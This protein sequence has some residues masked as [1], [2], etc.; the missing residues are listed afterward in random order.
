MQFVGGP[1]LAVGTWPGGNAYVGTA[2]VTASN[3]VNG[4]INTPAIGITPNNIPN[5]SP[6]YFATGLI[7]NPGPSV[8]AIATPYNDAGDMYHVVIDFSGTSSAAGVG[9][10]PAGSQFAILDLD[11]QEDYRKVSATDPANNPIATPWFG[12]TGGPNV[13]FDM[14]LP[15][16]TQGAIGASPTL[17][18][19]VLGVY[20]MFGIAWNFDVGMWRFTTTQPVRT[21]SFDMSK[22]SGNNAIGGG[23]AGWA[24]YTAPVPEPTSVALV[25]GA[26]AIGGCSFRRERCCQ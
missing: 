19:P 20:D 15:M 22:S 14:N 25:F 10:L 17:V 16:L 7:P 26:L 4:N 11:I 12:V 18:G 3:F 23:G 2:T 13:W 5:L 9:F 1:T 6:D 21:I 8:S 24:F